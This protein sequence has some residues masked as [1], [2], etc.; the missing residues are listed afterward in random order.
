MDKSKLIVSVLLNIYL[1]ILLI[2]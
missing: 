2:L 1:H